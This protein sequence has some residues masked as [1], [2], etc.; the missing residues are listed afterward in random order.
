[1][2]YSVILGRT[3]FFLLFVQLKKQWPEC[4]SVIERK[5]QFRLCNDTLNLTTLIPCKIFWSTN[6]II[7]SKF[8]NWILQWSTTKFQITRI[9]DSSKLSSNLQT[10]KLQSKLLSVANFALILNYLIHKILLQRNFFATFNRPETMFNNYTSCH[11]I[12]AFISN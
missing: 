1:M 5:F 3:G 4:Y 11:L 9:P 10:L 7:N 12:G 6:T 2:K 8:N